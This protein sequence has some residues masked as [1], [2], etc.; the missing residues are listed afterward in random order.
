[1]FKETDAYK[2]HDHISHPI[3]D[4]PV[5]GAD[6][7]PQPPPEHF[8]RKAKDMYTHDESPNGKVTDAGA[9]RIKIAM[10]KPN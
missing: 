3:H 1:M 9:A 7:S 8:F 4:K 5:M 2:L 10:E 6:G